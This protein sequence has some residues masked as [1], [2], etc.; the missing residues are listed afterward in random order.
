VK[1]EGKVTRRGDSG[2]WK[3]QRSPRGKQSGK[4]KGWERRKAVLPEIIRGGIKE[5]SHITRKRIVKAEEGGN[6]IEQKKGG[7]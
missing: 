3:V 7:E 5:S 2:K 4:R 1:E 6:D